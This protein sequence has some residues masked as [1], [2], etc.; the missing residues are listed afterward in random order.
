MLSVA[1]T[2]LVAHNYFFPESSTQLAGE[3]AVWRGLP[4]AIGHVLIFAYAC[5]LVCEV[6]RLLTSK[7]E[8]SVSAPV[9][10]EPNSL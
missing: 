6:Y 1:L 8:A 10:T 4:T 5:F 2:V 9:G 7:R 3:L